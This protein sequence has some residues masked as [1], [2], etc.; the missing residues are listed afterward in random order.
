MKELHQDR[1]SSEGEKA[2]ELAWLRERLPA[3][4]VT[5]YEGDDGFPDIV[6]L[7]GE[8]L[9]V[10]E[11]KGTRGAKKP[12]PNAKGSHLKTLIR[13]EQQEA[14]ISAFIKAGAEAGFVT[15]ENLDSLLEEIAR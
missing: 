5:A 2:R 6:A 13:W 1:L 14:W 4:W 12:G 3:F 15:P 10:M 9:L 8:R 11:I 7:K